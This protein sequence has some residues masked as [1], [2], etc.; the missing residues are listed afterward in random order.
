MMVSSGQKVTMVPVVLL[1]PPVL[2]G[3]TGLPWS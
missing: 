2:S 3:A 1:D